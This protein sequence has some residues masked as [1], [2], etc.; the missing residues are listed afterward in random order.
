MK[1][2][3][4][5]TH[6]LALRILVMLL[7]IPILASC[8][9]SEGARETTEQQGKPT[10]AKPTKR[11]A[12]TF[13]DGPQCRDAEYGPNTKSIVDELNKYGFHA[14]FFVVGKRIEKGNDTLSYIVQSGSEI[15]IHGYSHSSDRYYDS[16]SDAEY[17]EEINQTRD[18]IHYALPNYNIRT[19]RP[20]GGFI[21]DERIAQSPYSVIKWDV[22]SLDYQNT[23]RS[24]D[25]DEVCSQKVNTIVNN[26][27]SQ[28]QDGSIIL[29]HDIY[30]ST[31]DAT[32]IL[33]QRL[34]EEGYAVVSV[35]ELLGSSMQPGQ[36][37]YSAS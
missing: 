35:S 36:L 5:P 17:A 1:T 21:S 25:S 4:R 24:G 19:M 8:S 7:L 14:T 30:Q 26:V 2:A 20:V 23:Y 10:D 3:K 27:M 11:V 16:C 29:L 12:I 22:D 37:Y 31:Y 15:G 9:Y 28:V 34:K 6:S 33:L 32:V 13:D 18:A